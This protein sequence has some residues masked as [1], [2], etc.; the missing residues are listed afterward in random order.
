MFIAAYD[1]EF[2]I[3]RELPYGMHP[4]ATGY[5]VRLGGSFT[6]DDMR[7]NLD[8]LYSRLDESGSLFWWP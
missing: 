3:L 8:L 2:Q 6:Q 5:T 1:P 4:S 7:Q